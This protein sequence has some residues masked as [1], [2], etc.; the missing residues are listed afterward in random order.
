MIDDGRTLFRRIRASGWAAR[1][2]I[3][4]EING[5]LFLV[6]GQQYLLKSLRPGGVVMDSLSRHKVKGV[7]DAIESIKVQLL[8]LP[9]Y[10]S[11]FIPIALPS[12][13]LKEL[14]QSAE[15]RVVD[16]LLGACGKILGRFSESSFRSDFKHASYVAFK[17]NH[18]MP[19]CA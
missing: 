17:A 14:I 3:E 13:K 6:W 19:I 10:S 2:V 1:L 15:N 18:A 11:G 12:S 16:K 5:K 4:C 8:C 9:P 7:T